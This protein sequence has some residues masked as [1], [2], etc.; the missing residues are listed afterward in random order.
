MEEKKIEYKEWC[1]K[2]YED[3][4]RNWADTPKRKIEDVEELL[5]VRLNCFTGKNYGNKRLN[6]K[7]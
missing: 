2:Y 6:K 5:T 3:N 7:I 4:I 1:Q